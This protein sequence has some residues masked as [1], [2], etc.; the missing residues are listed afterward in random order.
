MI[1]VKEFSTILGKDT[2][3][4][5]LPMARREVV[6]PT[7]WWGMEPTRVLCQCSVMIYLKVLKRREKQLG[8]MKITQ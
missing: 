5:C 6:S 2:T 4:H 7:P 3:A 8:K 1:L